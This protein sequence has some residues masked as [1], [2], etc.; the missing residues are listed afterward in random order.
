MD[1]L[2]TMIGGYLKTSPQFLIAPHLGLIMPGVN[3]SEGHYTVGLKQNI[4][5]CEDVMMDLKKRGYKVGAGLGH[6]KGSSA[7][8]GAIANIDPKEIDI[9][10]IVLLSPTF[11]YR[12]MLPGNYTD[13][14]MTSLRSKGYFEHSPKGV[15]G[16]PL[17]VTM[18]GLEE[19]KRYNNSKVCDI[20][21]EREVDILVIRGSDDD[22][23]T[24]ESICQFMARLSKDISKDPKCIS[25]AKYLE[26]PNTSH[27]FTGTYNEVTKMVID[28]LGKK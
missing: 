28:F 23:S 12:P 20:I 8:L 27:G 4:E 10:K 15:P 5:V 24:F 11:S 16:R 3:M 6:S 2:H 1:M 9:N 26:I 19:R 14:Q 13:E 17:I 22:V 25:Q 18:E 7:L 21:S